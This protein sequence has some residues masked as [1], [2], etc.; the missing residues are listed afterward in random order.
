MEIVSRKELLTTLKLAES[1]DAVAQFQMGGLCYDL[2]SQ[3]GSERDEDSYKH[4]DKLE[5]EKLDWYRKSA[6]QGYAAAQHELAE[7]YIFELCMPPSEE[8]EREAIS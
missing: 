3:F 8:R 7:Y 1:G 6:E 4:A 5:Q 2:Y